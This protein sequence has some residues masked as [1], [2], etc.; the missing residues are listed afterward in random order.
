MFKP[1][2]AKRN[3]LSSWCTSTRRITRSCSV[4]GPR[5]EY[6][7]G[8]SDGLRTL[9]L[10]TNDVVG[11]VAMEDGIWCNELSLHV[12]VGTVGVV[13]AVF[14]EARPPRSCGSP[15]EE[16]TPPAEEKSNWKCVLEPGLTANFL[17]FKRLC[18]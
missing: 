7:R 2:V 12:E 1:G 3:P 16:E 18:L 15:V 11:N 10:C 9:E 6:D 14:W 4:V 8:D 17:R 13:G 5:L